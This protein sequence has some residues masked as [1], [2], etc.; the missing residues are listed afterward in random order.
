[1]EGEA[2]EGAD[3]GLAGAADVR[4]AGETVAGLPEITREIWTAAAAAAAMGEWME[5]GGVKDE[6]RVLR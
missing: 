1:M 5:G 4:L 6:R 2:F 3:E